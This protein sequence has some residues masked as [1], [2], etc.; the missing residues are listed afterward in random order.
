L[1]VL[2]FL[3]LLRWGVWVVVGVVDVGKNK[4][5]FWSDFFVREIGW[6]ESEFLGIVNKRGMVDTTDLTAD[7]FMLMPNM[8]EFMN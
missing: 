1:K 3:G 5:L 2:L 4:R 7:V 6:C 8:L